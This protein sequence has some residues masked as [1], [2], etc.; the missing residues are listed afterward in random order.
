MTIRAYLFVFLG[1]G[2]L[3]GF[4]FWW[5]TDWWAY[6]DFPDGPMP[7]FEMPWWIQLP[8]SSTVGCSGGLAAVAVV[9]LVI[10]LGQNSKASKSE[11]NIP[12]QSSINK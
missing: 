10:W 11:T 5:L 7:K 4:V 12:D 8:V 3:V 9:K 2:G 6:V 1:F